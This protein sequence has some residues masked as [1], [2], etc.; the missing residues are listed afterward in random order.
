MAAATPF[1]KSELE[2]PVN[3]CFAVKCDK[4][5]KTTWKGCGKH[6]DQVMSQVPKDDQCTCPRD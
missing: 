1:T 6:V 4:C 2:A 5:G 3:A